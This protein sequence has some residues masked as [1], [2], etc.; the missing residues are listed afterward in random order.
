MK[1]V[2]ARARFRPG[3]REEFMAQAGGF[4]AASRAEE[5]CLYFEMCIDPFDCD[6]GLTVECFVSSEAHEVHKAS[7]H[8]SAFKPVIEECLLE[9][10]FEDV[11]A[12]QSDLQFVEFEGPSA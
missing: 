5:G 1:Y 12:D 10:W 7:A 8:Y 6:A 9:G 3:K 4:L 2:I 11:V